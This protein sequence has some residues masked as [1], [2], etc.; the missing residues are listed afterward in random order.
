[1]FSNLSFKKYLT[2][3]AVSFGLA[4]LLWGLILFNRLPDLEYPFHYAAF[5]ILAV[6]GGMSLI[7]FSKNIKEILKSILA[8]V[9][10]YGVG[11]LV[12]V[13]W[14]YGLALTGIFILSLIP[15]TNNPTADKFFELIDLSQKS[16]GIGSF[17]LIFL[18]IGVFTGLSYALFLK[19]KIW[20]MIWRGG[21]GFA[22]GSLIGPI[23]GNLLGNAL[24]SLLIAYLI[25]FAVMSA[26]LGKFLAWGVYKFKK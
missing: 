19:T 2:V 7:G 20:P 22:F 23:I 25:T 3:N 12:I 10:G 21:V 5:L 6:L 4:G 9:L 11:L 17:W 18:I 15:F 16:I 14:I 26:V 24:N 8:G 1:M 13:V